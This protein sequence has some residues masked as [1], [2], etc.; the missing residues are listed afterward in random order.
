MSDEKRDQPKPTPGGAKPSAAS[1]GKTPAATGAPAAGSNPAKTELA[2]RTRDLDDSKPGGPDLTPG[3]RSLVRLG[4][5]LTALAVVILLF[6]IVGAVLLFR[7]QWLI[8]KQLDQMQDAAKQT[9]QA[10]TMAG[11]IA[12]S[13]KKSAE[14][15]TDIERAYVLLDASGSV[16]PKTIAGGAT[17]R[18]AFKNYGKTPATLRTVV[19][20]FYF[21][22]GPP[23]RLTPPQSNLA[24]PVIV[25]D[26]GAA[27][28]Y[29][30]PLD[31]NDSD[32][33]RAA[34][35]DGSLVAQA[36]LIYSDVM[37]E[38]HQ[39]DVCF[40]YQIKSNQFE[41]CAAVGLDSHN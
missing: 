31:A 16:L 30:L 23:T 10:L 17:V 13:A 3:E 25:T 40:T 7:Q 35:G 24:V 14:T 1:P 2:R 39:T 28:P 12:E 27:G 8:G 21:S 37:G 19:G 36:S 34:R 38:T 33:A 15:M 11:R 9:D 26:G 6:V 32:L 29:D 18:L 22:P 4:R 5:A 41:S 20:R